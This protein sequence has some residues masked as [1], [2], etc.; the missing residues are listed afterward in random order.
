M[1]KKEIKL[2]FM[3]IIPFAMSLFPKIEFFLLFL[4]SH[5]LFSHVLSHVTNVKNEIF[6][7]DFLVFHAL[8]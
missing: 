3:I 2:N 6:I 8:I 4:S 5:T 7:E 1:R